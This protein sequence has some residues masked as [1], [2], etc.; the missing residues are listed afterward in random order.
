MCRSSEEGSLCSQ[1]TSV[2]DEGSV[3]GSATDHLCNLRQ[4]TLSLR[5]WILVGYLLYTHLPIKN[6]GLILSSDAS[7]EIQ[8]HE[9]HCNNWIWTLLPVPQGPHRKW[10][11]WGPTA[12]Q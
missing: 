3:P 12:V 8:I 9:S 4:V 7:L 10:A 11:L 5:P 1:G 2:A 6:T